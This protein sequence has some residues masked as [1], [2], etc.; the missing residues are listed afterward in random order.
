MK[1]APNR[2]AVEIAIKNA[3]YVLKV[4]RCLLDQMEETDK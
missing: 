3:E 2:I 4:L 1:N